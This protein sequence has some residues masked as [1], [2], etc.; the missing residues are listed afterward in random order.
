MATRKTSGAAR[1]AAL[2]AVPVAV[3]TGLLAYQAMK[4]AAPGPD[5]PGAGAL[6]SDATAAGRGASAGGAGPTAAV[7]MPAGPL[8]ERPAAVCHALA[9]RLPDRL[10]DLPRR[11]V[12]AGP[13]QNAAYGDP[14]VTLACGTPGPAV[15][16]D[17]QYLRLNGVCWYA[18]TTTDG[19][20]W[21]AVGREVPLV[22][23][24]PPGYE[25]A[26]LAGLSS[27]VLPTVPQVTD[28]CA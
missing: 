17:A 18:T 8:A 2:V 19:A 1:I 15:P 12:T 14:P 22:V 20:L 21:S 24:L 10:G 9:A 28:P 23:R 7:P 26:I 13:D 16:L 6:S 11:P 4:P 3:L 27:A 5:T 25:G